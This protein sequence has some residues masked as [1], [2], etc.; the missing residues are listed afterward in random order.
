MD[1]STQMQGKM[2]WFNAEKG[3]GFIRT[4]EDER[5]YVASSGF[6]PD[7]LPEGRCAGREVAF[8]RQVREGDTRAVG[9]SFLSSDDPRRARAR[10][11]HGPRAH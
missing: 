11:S 10:H 3:F 4:E 5:L 8:E 2:L 7:S 1:E 9:V 6:L